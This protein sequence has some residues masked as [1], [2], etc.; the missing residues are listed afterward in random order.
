MYMQS[1]ATIVYEM[2]KP[3]QITNLITTAPRTATTRTKFAALG[4][5][6]LPCDALRCTVF[7]IVILSVRPSICHTRALCPHG[8]TYDHD[9]FTT[10]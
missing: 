3:Q 5:Q 4:D 10:W 6:F 2:K 9:F 8:L 1:L 7:V